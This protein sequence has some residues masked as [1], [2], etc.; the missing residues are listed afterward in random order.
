MRSNQQKARV[1]LYLLYFL[2]LD[3]DQPSPIG[4]TF[5][6][7]FYHDL[8]IPEDERTPADENVTSMDQLIQNIKYT[9][10]ELDKESDEFVEKLK[11]LGD[12]FIFG[13]EQLALF[14]K[15][16]YDTLS[17]ALQDDDENEDMD[18]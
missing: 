7:R 9:P 1:S 3:I 11:F 12:A 15:T 16:M 17:G 8:A 5:T 14:F 4:L 13:H 6:L 18:G 10:L 2:I